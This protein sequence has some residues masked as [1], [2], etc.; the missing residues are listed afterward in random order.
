MSIEEK[1]CV[2]TGASR[3][4]GRGIAEELGRAGG[5]VV[6]NYHT[7]EAQA[8]DVVDAIEESGGSAIAVQGNVAELEEMEAM[9]E[10]T[11]RAFGPAE[12]VVNN[13]GVTADQTFESMTSGEWESVV[14][15]NLDGAFNCIK[16]YFD[17]VYSA[18]TG[19]VINVS[20]MVGLKGNYGQ[21]NYAAAKSGLFGLTRTLALEM[22][23]SGTT[24]NCIAPGFTKTDMLEDVPEEIQESILEQIPLNRFAEPEDIAGLV[25][26]LAGS[27]SGYMTGQIIPI[28]GGMEW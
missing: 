6:V 17:D 14:S 15:V 1:T 9:S 12:V 8:H 13:A 21:A 7:S 28:T 27:R 18:N 3:G 2:V 22:A 25:R 23:G 11:R 19:R 5:D 16:A 4:I 20:S 24:V 10:T 26:Y